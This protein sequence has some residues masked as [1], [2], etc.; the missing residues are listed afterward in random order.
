MV[1]IQA[2]DDRS[3]RI[4][5]TQGKECL[6]PGDSEISN[7]KSLVWICLHYRRPGFNPWVGTIPWGNGYPLQYSCL[8]NPWTE[9]PDIIQQWIRHDWATFTFKSTS[10][11]EGKECES[12]RDLDSIITWVFGLSYMWGRGG[13]GRVSFCLWIGICVNVSPAKGGLCGA[14]ILF[15]SNILSPFLLAKTPDFALGQSFLST[16]LLEQLQRHRPGLSE[17]HPWPQGFVQGWTRDIR[18]NKV[19]YW[20]TCWEYWERDTLFFSQL[21]LNLEDDFTVLF[22]PRRT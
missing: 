22:P 17:T 20:N 15:S 12:P 13:D 2:T 11:S 5:L 14:V 18:T 10:N 3:L 4:H 9:K 16:L 21:V 8:G 7:Y 1:I 6:S 19:K